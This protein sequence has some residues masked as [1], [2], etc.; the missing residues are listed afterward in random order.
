VPER[1]H[2]R[3]SLTDGRLL[4]DAQRRRSAVGHGYRGQRRFVPEVGVARMVGGSC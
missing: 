2:G 1:V 3:S 4:P